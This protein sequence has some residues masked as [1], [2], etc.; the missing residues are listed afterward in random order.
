[1]LVA[2]DAILSIS[3]FSS[4]VRYSRFEGKLPASIPSELPDVLG[5]T[6]VMSGVFGVASG[7]SGVLGSVTGV[8][9]AV[10]STAAVSLSAAVRLSVLL[11]SPSHPLATSV[12]ASN[13]HSNSSLA[14]MYG[15][16]MPQVDWK[17]DYFSTGEA[18]VAR[19]G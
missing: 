4:S 18:R 12:L 9:D 10:G 11:P 19:Y 6:A 14:F 8:A 16:H 2:A 15:N 7:V 5:S 13:K 1:M 3:A 17:Q